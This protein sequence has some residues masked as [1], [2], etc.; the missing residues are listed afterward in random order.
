MLRLYAQEKIHKFT[1]R[2]HFCEILISGLQ[3]SHS[4][5]TQDIVVSLCVYLLRIQKML[6]T[7]CL[8][9]ND[10]MGVTCA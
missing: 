6:H 9:R 4:K 3:K 10:F 1:Q 7:E 5:T 2:V 8:N